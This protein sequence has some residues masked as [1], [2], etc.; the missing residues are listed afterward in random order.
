MSNLVMQ[1]IGATA[2]V[3]FGVYGAVVASKEKKAALDDQRDIQATLDSLV[4]N[5]QEI[6]N[7]YDEIQDL[8][9]MLNNPMANLGVATQAADMQIEQ[10]DISLANTLDTLR[11]TGASAGGATALAQAAL[12]SKKGVSA[13]IEKQEAQNEQLKA[14]G[15]QMLQQR[16][17][18]EAQRV[19]KARARGEMFMYGEQEKRELMELDR[20]AG[21]LEN[22]QA[23]EMNAIASRNAAISAAVGGVSNLGSFYQPTDLID[24][25]AYLN[26][27]AYGGSNMGL[28]PVAYVPGVDAQGNEVSM[29]PPGY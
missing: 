26:S 16:Q 7:P 17:L 28:G 27:Q 9:G 1:I 25:D 13:S 18:A 5:R 10:A 2:Q 21:M 15:E 6:I 29:R 23:R 24:P 22:A 8:S 3:G 20:T 12:Q 19:Q 11:A 4:D 14:Q